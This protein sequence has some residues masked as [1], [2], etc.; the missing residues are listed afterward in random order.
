MPPRPWHKFYDPGVPAEVVFEDVTLAQWLERATRS[1]ADR[2]ALIFQNRTLTYRELKDHVDRLATALAELGV[3]QGDRVAIQFPNLPHFMISYYALQ[4]LGAVAVPTNPLYT[5]REI[6]YQ[7]NDAECTAALLPDFIYAAKVASMR[8]HLP[9]RHYVVGSIP[10][11][12]GFPLNLLAPLKLKRATPPLMAAFET[13]PTVHRFADLVRAA[14]PSLPAATISMSDLSTLLYTGGT[15][16]VSKGAMLTHRNLS[17]NVQQMRAWFAQAAEGREVI[18]GAL[19]FFHSFGL[20]VCMNLAV[21]LAATLVLIPNPRDIPAIVKSIQKH[22]IT[23]MAAV[24]ATFQAINQYP[25]IERADLSSVKMCNS[26]AAPLPVEVLQR[27]EQLTGG[28]ISEGFGLTETSPVTHCN[29]LFSQRKVGSIGVPL[30]SSDARVVDAEDGVTVKPPGEVGELLLAGPQVMQGYWKKPEETAKVLRDGWLYTGDLCRVDEDGYH[31]IV[32]RKKDMILSSGFNVYPDEIDRVL[33]A[34][35]AVLEAASIG[36]PD[37][38]RGES[39]KSFVVLR[40]G[41]R[42]SEEELLVHCKEQL[43]AYKVP[44]EIEFRDALPRSTV[45]KI[46]RRELRAEEMAKR[47]KAM[48]A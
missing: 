39:V 29:P 47:G 42:A 32:G 22:R 26:G 40:P 21:R 5:P 6:E 12:L 46:L 16:G 7:W 11:Y 20:T 45:L 44:K 23:L 35:P 37:P 14:A 15:T 34:H 43:A 4:T 41:M 48:K 3:K 19:P 17:C 36:V 38:K 33:M 2:P 8:S 13:S 28:K 1:H 10:E 30:P 18:L 31:F 25:G 24:P 9:V 27:F